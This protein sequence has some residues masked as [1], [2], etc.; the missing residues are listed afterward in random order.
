VVRGGIARDNGHLTTK[1]TA[2][3]TKAVRTNDPTSDTGVAR[4]AMKFEVVVI[5]VSDV[6]RAKEFYLSWGGG[7]TPTTTAVKSSG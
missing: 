4:V 7:W 6:D 3:S 2:M 5:P 1:E